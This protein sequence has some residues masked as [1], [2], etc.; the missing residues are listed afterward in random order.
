MSAICV[1]RHHADLTEGLSNSVD[2][3]GIPKLAPYFFVE[4]GYGIAGSG[5]YGQ[6]RSPG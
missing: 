5:I 4:P 2:R 6:S 3:V 1:S